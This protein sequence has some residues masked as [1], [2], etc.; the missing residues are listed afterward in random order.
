MSPQTTLPPS[1]F[2]CPSISQVFCPATSTEKS[3]WPL[4][5]TVCWL[6]YLPACIPRKISPG[7]A[8]RPPPVRETSNLEVYKLIIC[9]QALPEAGLQPVRVVSRNFS[10]AE[11]FTDGL[12]VVVVGG[13]LIVGKTT[14]TLSQARLNLSPAEGP[15]RVCVSLL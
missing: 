7:T 13:R 4:S 2:S 10:F 8:T 5:L 1:Y 9:S 15:L 6:F 3:S 14:L 11:S 12:G